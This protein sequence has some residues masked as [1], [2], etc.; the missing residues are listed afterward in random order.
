[1]SVGKLTS[2][3]EVRKDP[4]L[5]KQFIKERV[6]DGYGTGDADELDAGL[7]S[8]LKNSP[9]AD[10]TSPKASDAD[11]SGTQ[12]PPDTSADASEK[13]KRESRE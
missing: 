9:A 6:Q 8:I 2:L 7:T 10:Q 11:C 3:E 5:L 13:P 12:T 4:K 1:M